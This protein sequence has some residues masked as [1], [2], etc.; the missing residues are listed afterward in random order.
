MP[1]SGRGRIIN[2]LLPSPPRGEGSKKEK[3]KSLKM[4]PTLT[5]S[6]ATHHGRAARWL[7]AWAVL[8]AAFT[9]PLLALGAEVTTRRVGMVDRQGFREPW[10]LIALWLQGE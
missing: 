4:A 1:T 10:H 2:V 5:P 6:V 8:T 3:Q 9:L 7:N